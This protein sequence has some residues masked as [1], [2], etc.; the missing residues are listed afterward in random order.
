M[1]GRNICFPISIASDASTFGD[2]LWDKKKRLNEA[3]RL[4]ILCSGWRKAFQVHSNSK[5]EIQIPLFLS[6]RT[7]LGNFPEPLGLHFSM[8]H[9]TIET[10]TTAAQKEK[11]LPLVRGVKIIGTY[12]QTEMGHG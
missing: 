12:A 6:C 3:K 1:P 10:Q 11:W 2:C 5:T 9:K 8:F 7:C 4:F